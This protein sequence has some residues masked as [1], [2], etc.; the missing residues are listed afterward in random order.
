MPGD[1]AGIARGW[2]AGARARWARI[3]G[4]PNGRQVSGAP[5]REGW[6]SSSISG[7]YFR[8]GGER[9][10]ATSTAV[11]TEWPS[12]RFISSFLI[13]LT[14]PS[15]VSPSTIAACC[16][17]LPAASPAISL[18]LAPCSFLWKGGKGESWLPGPTSFFDGPQLWQGCAITSSLL[19]RAGLRLRAQ[20]LAEGD[21][22]HGSPLSEVPR[23]GPSRE[24][25]D[26]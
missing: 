11:G 14:G 16:W 3:R 19:C 13:R 9:S 7:G 12:I 26:R 5:L 22:C 4:A 24:G 17:R 21:G 23:E 6:T 25:G 8:P 20:G 10:V 2:P 15:F 18:G 1:V